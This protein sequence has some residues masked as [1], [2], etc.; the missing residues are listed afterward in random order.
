MAKDWVRVG[1]VNVHGRTFH[2]ARGQDIQHLQ[3]NTRPVTWE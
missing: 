1:S 3:L 2:V